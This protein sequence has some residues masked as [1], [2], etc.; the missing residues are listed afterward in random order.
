MANFNLTQFQSQ[1]LGG[2]SLARTNRFE[3]LINSPPQLSV[4]SELVSLYVEQTNFPMLSIASKPFRIHNSPAEQ[5]PTAIEH[6]G[7]GIMFTIHLD[8]QM[9][10]KRYF[11]EWCALIIDKDNFLV[12]YASNYMTTVLIRQL[13]EQ[14]NI[15]YEVELIDAFPRNINLIPLDHNAVNQ[16]HKLNVLLAYRYWKETTSFYAIDTPLPIQYPQVPRTDNR[17]FL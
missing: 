7:E 14:D 10:I 2:T 12:N 6:G 9:N 17:I 4:Y 5:R 11:D 1:V 8:A 15:T 16:T 3:V 13:D